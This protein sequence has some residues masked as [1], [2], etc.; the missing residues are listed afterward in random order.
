M[1]FPL[2]LLIYCYRI[3]WAWPDDETTKRAN[4]ENGEN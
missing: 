1:I 2:A 4:L 3:A